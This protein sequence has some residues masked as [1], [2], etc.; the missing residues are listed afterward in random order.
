MHEEQDKWLKQR[1]VND[2][3][4]N[5]EAHNII[6]LLLLYS[7][8]QGNPDEIVNRLLERFGSIS[9]V[10]DAPVPELMRVDG[11]NEDSAILIS[12]IPHLS[13]KYIEDKSTKSEICG[14]ENI[15]EFA[16]KC[17]VGITTEHF[18]LIC[19]DN[20]GT[21]LNYHFVA[22]GSVDSTNVDLRK[23]IYIL[24]G[25]NATAAVIAH[26][27]PRGNSMPSKKDLKTTMTIASA[28]KPIGIK[29]LDNV[30]VS[31]S[32][33]TSMAEYPKKFGCYLNPV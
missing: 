13:R 22:K 5:F 25:S 27:H 11:M 3:L 18:L 31:T 19:V 12:M 33:Y 32:D 10:F 7:Q 23:I 17:F 16:S 8:P 9:E 30:I 1:F 21:M 29:L 6:K 26:N 2:G 4:Q 24:L 15:A 20:K 14:V 28:L